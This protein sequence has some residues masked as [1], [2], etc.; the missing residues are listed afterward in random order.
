MCSKAVLTVVVPAP[1]EPVTATTG[2]CL[3]MS[4]RIPVVISSYWLR[5]FIDVAYAIS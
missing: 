3:D 5:L 4:L 2:C 1:D